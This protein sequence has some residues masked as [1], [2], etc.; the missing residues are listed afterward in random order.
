MLK[1]K[2]LNKNGLDE[3]DQHKTATNE[4]D[5]ETGPWFVSTKRIVNEMKRIGMKRIHK[6]KTRNASPIRVV[7]FAA[8]K[9]LDV[10]LTRATKIPDGRWSMNPSYHLECRAQLNT[11]CC[12]DNMRAC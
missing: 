6:P 4:T 10:V 3:T 9:N 12:A 7:G 11:D 8:L 5:G 2:E 1:N